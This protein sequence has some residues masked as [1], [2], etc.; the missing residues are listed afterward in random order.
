[1]TPLDTFLA[2]VSELLSREQLRIVERFDK[3][4]GAR[5]YSLPDYESA[6]QI[7]H[8]IIREMKSAL[9]KAEKRV[10]MCIYGSSDTSTDPE[11][12]FRQGSYHAWCESGA[13]ARDTLS[14][15]NRLCGGK[16][17]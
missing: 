12:A 7:S 13:E 15:L 14:R 10:G 16:D 8:A 17:E 11:V 5:D 9:E 3:V 1:M 4:T 6:L 2:E